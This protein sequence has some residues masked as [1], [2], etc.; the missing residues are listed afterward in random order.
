[1]LDVARCYG[2]MAMMHAENTDCIEWLTRR[3]EAAGPAAL[4]KFRWARTQGLQ[5]QAETCPQDLFLTPTDLGFNDSY[6][7]ER[8][9]YSLPPGCKAKQGVICKGFADSLFPMFSSDHA[10][11]RFND[12]HCKKP[13]G[14]QAS[15][16]H[17][18]NGMRG[19]ETRTPLLCSEAVLA[20]PI[21]RNRFVASTATNSAK[22]HARFPR[23]RLPSPQPHRATDMA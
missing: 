13:G 3:L 6:L 7:G 22:G 14:T 18:P 8:C 21:A 12:Q 20:G 1:M 16:R 15:R 5:M 10:L 2:A 4:E 17:I 9:V 23:W 11:F 19:I